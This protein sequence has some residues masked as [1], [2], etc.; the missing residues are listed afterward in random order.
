MIDVQRLRVLSSVVASG[1]VS[2]A[3]VSMGYTP[4]AISQQLTALQK[5]T[6]LQ[7]VQRVGRGIEP[8]VA[9]ERLAAEAR[10]VLASISGVE[11]LVADLRTGRVGSLSI[12]YFSSAGAAWLPP[13]VAALITEFPDLRLDLRLSEWGD[14]TRSPVAD[15]EVFVARNRPVPAHGYTIHHL[16]DDPYVVIV[17]AGHRFAG[18][19]QVTLGELT[20]DLW[21]DNDFNRGTCRQILLDA[22]AGAGFVPDFPVET[23]DYPTAIQFVAA[24]VG[25]TVMPLLGAVNLPTQV[26]AVPVSD[27]QLIRHIWVAVRG[28]VQQHPAVHRVLEL[29][30]RRV[31]S[32]STK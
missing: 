5:S 29:L 26:V 7:L 2:A 20:A 4:S 12:C 25:I 1:S 27:R 24:G 17:P 3:A 30:H 13:I 22:C 21:V 19:D 32:G 31:G 14:D 8:T 15:I 23:P 18:R 9:G 6:G 16:Q 11:A 10:R 28:S